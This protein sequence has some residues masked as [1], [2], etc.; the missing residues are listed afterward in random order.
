MEQTGEVW[1]L[2]SLW[3]LLLYMS[4]ETI[5]SVSLPGLSWSSPRPPILSVHAS[6]LSLINISLYIDLDIYIYHLFSLLCLSLLSL[7]G[8]CTRSFSTPTPPHFPFLLYSPRKEKGTHSTHAFL[9]IDIPLTQKHAH[10]W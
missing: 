6:S 7:S 9:P 1:A 5:F 2:L 3:R 8:G 4:P 10:A